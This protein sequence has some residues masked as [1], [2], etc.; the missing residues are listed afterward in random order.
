REVGIV[1][2]VQG[3]FAPGGLRFTPAEPSRPLD[4]RHGARLAAATVTRVETDAPTGTAAALVNL[5]ADAASSPGYVTADACSALATGPQSRSSL[6]HIAGAATSNLAVVNVDADGSLCLFN[7]TA[8]HLIV[9][10]QGFFVPTESAEALG[11]AAVTPVRL[12]DTRDTPEPAAAGAIVRVETG[13]AGV[14]AA[15]VSIAMT[16]AATAGYVTADRC[17]V[18]V[19]GPQQTSSGNHRA[20]LAS[21]NLAAVSV[22]ADGAFCI[23]TSAAVELAVDLQGTF[24]TDATGGLVPI[25]PTRVFDQRPPARP[26]TP[27]TSCTSVVHIGDS[28][29]VGM[30]S[31]S[32]ISDPTR[33]LDAHQPTDGDLRSAFDRGDLARPGQRLQRRRR[34]QGR[35]LSRMLGVRARHHRHRQHRGWWR[36]QPSSAD[37]QDDGGGRR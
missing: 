33:R 7:Q 37:R 31:P 28:T 16:D 21:A 2:D 27:T 15:L 17:S 35:G 18:L 36:R 14:A 3:G 12:L 9:D 19:P 29:S 34:T 6:N 24:S 32:Y 23:Y 13:H 30:I 20:G 26:A 25:A 1:V 22:D 5:T 8:T 4:T 10:V 11:Y